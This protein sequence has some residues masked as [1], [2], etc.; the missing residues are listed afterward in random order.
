M[1]QEWLKSVGVNVTR[2][3]RPHEQSEERTRRKKLRGTGGEITVAT[4]QTIGSVKEE[5]KQVI[6]GEYTV[7]QHIAPQKVYTVSI[8]VINNK[9]IIKLIIKN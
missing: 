3:K 8:A 7:G 5:M 1:A 9:L 6:S 4:P 2:F